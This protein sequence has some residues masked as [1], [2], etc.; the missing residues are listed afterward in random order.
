MIPAPARL[1]DRPHATCAER[2][3]ARGV[4]RVESGFRPAIRVRGAIEHDSRRARDPS[5]GFGTRSE[6]PPRG[7]VERRAGSDSGGAP[8]A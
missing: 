1:L 3:S 6:A 4:V 7:G 5:N 8:W 2:A